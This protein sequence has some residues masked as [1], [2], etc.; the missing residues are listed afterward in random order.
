MA[1]EPFKTFDED[2][3]EALAER[4]AA[5]VVERLQAAELL[6]PARPVDA[7]AVAEAIGMSAEFVRDHA[8]EL[9]GRRCGDG[10]RPR[11]RFDLDEALKAWGARSATVRSQGA[12]APLPSRKRASRRAASVELLPIQRPNDAGNGGRRAA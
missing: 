10:P 8:D 9:G 3:F 6:R 1:A 5:L 7:A 2:A 11:L 12:E 4:V